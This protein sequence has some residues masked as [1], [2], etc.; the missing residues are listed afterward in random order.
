MKAIG[1]TSAGPVDRPDALVEPE[2]SRWYS[3]VDW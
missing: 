2:A 3:D 1:Y